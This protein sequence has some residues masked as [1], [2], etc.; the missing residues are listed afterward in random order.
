[1]GGGSFYTAFFIFLS[2]AARTVNHF[3]AYVGDEPFVHRIVL[4]QT[5]K[6]FNISLE[7]S[8]IVWYT[9]V[10]WVAKS[11]NVVAI[12]QL[13]SNANAISFIFFAFTIQF[14][15]KLIYGNYIHF[16]PSL[17][18]K[19]RIA[20]RCYIRCKLLKNLIVLSIQVQH[21]YFVYKM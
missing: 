19:G 14:N 18:V 2:A 4:P 20:F 6:L 17:S 8:N 9:P 10:F 21:L 15:C 5:A 16:I 11:G 7:L 13:I 1:M 3:F 12:Y